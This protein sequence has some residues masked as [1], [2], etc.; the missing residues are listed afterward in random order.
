TAAAPRAAAAALVAAHRRGALPLRDL[1]RAAERV[2]RPRTSRTAR[3][4]GG[5]PAAE[6]DGGA[7][8]MAMA[9]RAVTT[10]APGPPG[11]TRALNG[12]VAVIFP[13]FSD[14]AP[15]ITIEP[16]LCDE[17][18]YLARAF[19]RAGIAPRTALVG[20]E[21]TAA[22]IEGAAALAEGADAAVLFLFDAHLY[23]SNRTLLDAVQRRARALAV[24]LLRD[25]YDASLLA[26]RVLGV[27]AFGFRRCQLDAVIARLAYP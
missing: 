19:G 7:L 27:T 21:P 26:P 4:E 5:P 16:E 8:A 3:F 15:R 13:R 23:P 6:R 14:L 20:I 25:P 11:F 24:V 10:I 12:A 17:K 22:E 18:A 2:R 9:A 1:E